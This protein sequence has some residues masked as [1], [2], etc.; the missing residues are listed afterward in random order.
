MLYYSRV[1]QMQKYKA[2]QKRTIKR[3][4]NIE[5]EKAKLNR[6]IFILELCRESDEELWK[7]LILLQL[8]DLKILKGRE[9]NKIKNEMRRK[10]RKLKY[11]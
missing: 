10:R 7:Q 3:L 11:E 6:M 2:V 8:E 9:G 5:E 4:E 1:M